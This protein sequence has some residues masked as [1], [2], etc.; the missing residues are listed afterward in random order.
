MEKHI[1]TSSMKHTEN[2]MA[3]NYDVVIFQKKNIKNCWTMFK[4]TLL[5]IWSKKY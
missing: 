2:N 1:L 4:K 5:K 3:K